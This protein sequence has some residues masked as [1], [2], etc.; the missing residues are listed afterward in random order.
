MSRGFCRE[1]ILMCTVTRTEPTI[2]RIGAGIRQ[3]CSAPCRASCGSGGCRRAWYGH[4]ERTA[5]HP[6]LG[7][8]IALSLWKMVFYYAGGD[9]DDIWAIRPYVLECQGDDPV[10]DPW[11]EKRQDDPCRWRR[12]LV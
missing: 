4:D 11:V 5:E 10:H 3:D 6:Y 9:K 12:I 8:G 1:Q 7:A 2:Y